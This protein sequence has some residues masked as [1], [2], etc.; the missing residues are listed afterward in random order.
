MTAPSEHTHQD[1][2]PFTGE[3]FI[4][5]L[6][7]EIWLEHWHR[8]HFAQ[9]LVAGKRVI[10][11]ACGEGYGSALLAN[12][13]LQVEGV[14]VSAQAIAHAQQTYAAQANLH[15]HQASCTAIPLPDAYADVVISFETVEHIHEQSAFLSEI[16]RVLKPDGYLLMSC[17]NKAEYTDAQGF[18]NEFH[19][20]ELY[21]DE[22]QAL[23]AS[24]FPAQ[25]WFGQRNVTASMITFESALAEPLMDASFSGNSVIA[26]AALQ[27]QA[28]DGAQAANAASTADVNAANTGALS[29]PLYFLVFAAKQPQYLPDSAQLSLH[30]DS[31]EWLKRDYAKVLRQLET[32]VARGHTHE[33]EIEVLKQE[34]RVMAT[35]LDAV[36]ETQDKLNHRLQQD[37]QSLASLQDQQASAL[38]AAQHT[39]ALETSLAHSEHLAQ[40]RASLRWWL[41]LPLYRLR[42]WLTGHKP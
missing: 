28:S 5:G 33:R 11:V 41:V 26:T 42:C 30:I 1:V 15:F 19:V 39:Q 6:P 25:R 8:Y 14:D 7:G 36:R 2:L 31:G 29:Q 24:R 38:K 35:A 23:I 21:A 22:L 18:Q 13:A 16:A 12:S 20:K 34:K 17:P 9:R 40:Y 10:D 32:M 3:R 37:S 27:L 4:P